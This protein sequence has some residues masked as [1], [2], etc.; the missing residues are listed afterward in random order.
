MDQQKIF[1]Q[2]PSEI[3]K[4]FEVFKN[5]PDS[6]RLVGGSVRD[7]LLGKKFSDFDFATKFLPEK[8]EEILR[9]NR[10]KA[11]PT[12]KKFGT[13]TAVVD[14]KNFEITTLRKD[15]ETDG[16]HC[17]PEFVDDYKLDAARRDFT[18]NA[19]YLDAQGVVHD[20]FGGIDDLKNQKVHFIGDANQRIEE[21][22][23][24]ILRFFRFSCSY[25]A[26]LDFE[27]L[28]ACVN[29]RENLKKLSRERVRSEILKM[30][31][32]AN[33]QNLLKIFAVLI[34]KKITAELFASELNLQSLRQLFF[35]EEKFD[36]VADLRVKVAA[37]FC[38]SKTD[39]EKFFGEICATNLEKKF[40][41]FAVQQNSQSLDLQSLKR[42]LAFYDKR[43]VLDFYLFKCVKDYREISAQNLQFLHEFE[44]SKF[45]LCGED[46]INIGLKGQEIGVAVERLKNLWADGDFKAD[47]KT[48]LQLL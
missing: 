23:L 39:L 9:Q 12:G 2:L 6:I 8:I 30:L 47:K 44:L 43:D 25:A 20:Y 34:D 41:N 37:L 16:R 7:L 21:D 15:N 27:G 36:F 45:P 3:K 5:Y 13:I 14:G 22:F 40:F 42:L 33:K 48:L 29:Q 17:E 35:N 4:I 11:I 24:R 1:L 46:L 19:L 10:I 31:N 38:S 28:K 26:E 32:S 18:M